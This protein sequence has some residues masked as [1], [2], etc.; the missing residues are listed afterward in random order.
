MSVDNSYLLLSLEFD[1]NFHQ[2]MD[3]S[4]ILNPSNMYSDPS[5]S[6]YKPVTYQ[7]RAV[8]GHL[9]VVV[10]NVG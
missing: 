2:L 10:G 3:F 9:D 4:T 8:C 7:N 1:W 6:S 5:T